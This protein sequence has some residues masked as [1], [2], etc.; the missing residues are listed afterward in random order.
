M[1]RNQLSRSLPSQEINALNHVEVAAQAAGST[2][3]TRNLEL[4]SE[5]RHRNVGMMHLEEKDRQ[6]R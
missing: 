5:S 6:R 2:R 4:N 1:V 3:R